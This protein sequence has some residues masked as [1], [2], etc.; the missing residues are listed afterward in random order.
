MISS[1][2]TDDGGKKRKKAKQMK[3]LKNLLCD[4]L[5]LK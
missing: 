4:E 1:C 5:P 2:D 3:F